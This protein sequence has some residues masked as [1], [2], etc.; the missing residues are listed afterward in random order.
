MDN[1]FH[2]VVQLKAEQELVTQSF[3]N[4]FNSYAKAF[5]KQFNRTGSLFEKH[6]KRIKLNDE[7]YLRQLIVYIH[8]NPTHHLEVDFRAFKFSSYQAMLSSK[9]TKLQKEEVLL[10]FGGKE[11]FIF[12]HK[13]RNDYLSEKYALE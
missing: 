9:E 4:F 6:F 1:H 2:L 5:N 13:E 11:N 12:S 8:L 3:S 10:L 7:T